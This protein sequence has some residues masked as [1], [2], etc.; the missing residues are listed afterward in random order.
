MV[1]TST[2]REKSPS[3]GL[4]Q[5]GDSGAPTELV[6]GSAFLPY[7]KFPTY[8]AKDFY[9]RVTNLIRLYEKQAL[10]ERALAEQIKIETSLFVQDEISRQL[11]EALGWRRLSKSLFGSR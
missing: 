1:D 5:G 9:G 7:K 8:L 2:I 4:A 6:A 3:K 10:T 11:N